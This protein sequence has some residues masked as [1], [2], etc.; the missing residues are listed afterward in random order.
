[1]T[2]YQNTAHFLSI[3]STCDDE[4]EKTATFKWSKLQKLHFLSGLSWNYLCWLRVDPNWNSKWQ[5][6]KNIYNHREQF[7]RY[8]LSSAV[9]VV[10]VCVYVFFIVATPF[11]PQFQNFG[12]PF[13]VWISKN[14]VF[15]FWK[16]FLLS[17]LGIDLTP[18]ICN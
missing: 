17:Y 8:N 6:S 1:M 2:I 15:K 7:F 3:Q 18:S 5:K 4:V 9:C 10:G 13:L 14:G 12:L 11:N 16:L